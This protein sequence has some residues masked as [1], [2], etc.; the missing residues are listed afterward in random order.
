[1]LGILLSVDF[2]VCDAILVA[3]GNFVVFGLML[4]FVFVLVFTYGI[5][6]V[7][8]MKADVYYSLNRKQETDLGDLGQGGV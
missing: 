1:M 5:S 7:W 4:E 2:S 8:P 3:G 6:L